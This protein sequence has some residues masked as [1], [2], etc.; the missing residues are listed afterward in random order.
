[1][2]SLDFSRIPPVIA[3]IKEKSHYSR[4]VFIKNKDYELLFRS[5]LPTIGA[6]HLIPLKAKAW[7]ELTTKR[8]VGHQ[9]SLEGLW[10]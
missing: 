4:K 9:I 7:L 2:Q 1:M 3:I 8:L 10:L 5:A 6:A